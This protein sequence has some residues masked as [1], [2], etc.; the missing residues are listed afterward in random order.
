MI[1]GLLRNFLVIYAVGFLI[2][3]Y[4]IKDNADFNVPRD[5]ST[6]Q[7]VA[8]KEINKIFIVGKEYAKEIKDKILIEAQEASNKGK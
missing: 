2:Y 1:F 4:L 5:Y 7:T 3:S 6:L 8:T